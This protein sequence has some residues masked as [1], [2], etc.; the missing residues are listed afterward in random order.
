MIINHPV[1]ISQ[2]ITLTFSI[3]ESLLIKT[4]SWISI[5]INL[6]H[7][8]LT[9]YQTFYR[10]WIHCASIKIHFVFF[11]PIESDLQSTIFWKT[12]HSIHST[13]HQIILSQ[14][15]FCRIIHRKKVYKSILYYHSFILFTPLFYRHAPSHSLNYVGIYL[16][17]KHIHVVIMRPTN[18]VPPKCYYKYN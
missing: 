5:E 13:L 10:E 3:Y 9:K 2:R 16:I 6:F 4:F 8:I 12:F 15:L 14:F 17:G 18:Y 7:I 1:F 11:L